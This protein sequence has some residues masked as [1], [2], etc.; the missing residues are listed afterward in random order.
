VRLPPFWRGLSERAGKSLTGGVVSF[1]FTFWV[2]HLVALTPLEQAGV[3]AGGVTVFS[4]VASLIS[5]NA[6]RTPKNS[7]S[8]VQE[9][10][11]TNRG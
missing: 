11:G 7:P 1:L 9:G 5:R 3:Y 4:I 6:P 10:A 2:E 8:L